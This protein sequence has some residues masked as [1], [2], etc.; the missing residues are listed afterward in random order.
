MTRPV[1]T[2]RP[3]TRAQ[4]SMTLS[5]QLFLGLFILAGATVGLFILAGATVGLFIQGVD[6]RL[7]EEAGAIIVDGISRALG[8]WSRVLDPALF[9][10]EY[11]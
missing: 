3:G 9:I 5:A 8:M 7:L 10:R 6:D 2:G 4:R 11:G 1:K